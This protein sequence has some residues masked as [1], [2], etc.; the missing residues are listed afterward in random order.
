M[1]Q[2][3]PTEKY[4]FR[5]FVFDDTNKGVAEGLLGCSL[6]SGEGKVPL[7]ITRVYW[8]GFVGHGKKHCQIKLKAAQR[9]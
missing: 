2:T 7:L 3:E 9:V 8:M 4:C 5:G 6:L 1:K